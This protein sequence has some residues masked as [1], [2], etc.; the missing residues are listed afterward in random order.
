[1]DIGF[2]SLGCSK[3][4]VDTEI[5]M[6]LLSSAGHKIVNS[7]ERADVVIINTCG[8]IGEAKEESINTILETAELKAGGILQ[9]LVATGCLSQRYGKELFDEMP[10]LD[11]VIGISYFVAINDI[12]T[13]LENGDRILKVGPPPD[14]F[15]EKGPRI[16]STPPGSAYLKIVEGCNNHCS[17][18]AIPSI[19]GKLRSRPLAE[20]VKEAHILAGQ[21][22]KE[23][24][25]I[26]QDTANYGYDLQGK[27][28]L[29]QLLKELQDKVDGIDW[30]RLLYL[31]PA[32]INDD[33]I[34]SIASL[35]KVIPYLDIPI[36]HVSSKILK[37]MNR[38]HER[39]YLE[40]LID[41]LKTEIDDL[42]LRTTVMLGFP[43]EEEAD[44]EELYH[45][46]EKVEF[47]WLGAF[48]YNCE[49]GTAAAGLPHQIEEA[50][51][52]N[53]LD[54]ILELQ[55]KISRKKNIARINS[56]EKILVSGQL[57]SNL[58][59]GRAYFQAPEVDGITLI[60][61]SSK[62]PR[63]EFTQVRFAGV[64]NYDM[65]GELIDEPAQ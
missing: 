2:I 39:N 47:D 35:S 15:I 28:L 3:N 4:R 37:M 31:H 33:I 22:I 25:V 52:K 61:S 9:Y 63:G 21:G 7:V 10:E 55:Q 38:K 26:A 51:K 16:I 59:I 54:T 27:Y 29:P 58:Y 5:M 24:V 50:V 40:A 13:E 65:I 23:L 44:F 46:I 18:C 11:A 6:A 17:Y 36:Q 45:F 57:S 64:R 42:V 20:L 8:F 62:L 60:K 19:K 30:I 53:R 1:M 32:H 56:S 12:L 14:T 49:E 48:T 41:K 43:G 34:N